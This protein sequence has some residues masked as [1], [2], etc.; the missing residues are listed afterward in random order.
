MGTRDLLFS[1]QRHLALLMG[2]S[3][4]TRTVARDSQATSSHTGLH[5][6]LPAAATLP[7]HPDLL[8][9]GF[10]SRCPPSPFLIC[11]ASPL[12][13]PFPH[14]LNPF[15]FLLDIRG[16]ESAAR[17]NGGGRRFF[18]PASILIGHSH[19][20]RSPTSS[21]AV[22]ASSAESDNRSSMTPQTLET[23]VYCKDWLSE[24]KS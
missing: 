16:I 21:T 1:P 10:R 14:R 3:S 5:R 8:H 24:G 4:A 13:C 2:Q 11:S 20:P 6:P 7:T 15:I 18:A 23:L 12:S 17:S 22:G 19:W 9:D